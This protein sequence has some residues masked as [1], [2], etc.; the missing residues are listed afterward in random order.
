MDRLD[1]LGWAAGI[2]VMAHGV[3]LGVRVTDPAAMGSALS[4]LPPG[5]RLARGP[6]V[7]HLFSLVVG[8][9]VSPRGSVRRLNLLYRDALR[10]ARDREWEPVLE[11]LE[12]ELRRTVAEFAPRRVFVH[13]GVVRWRGRAILVPG[14]TF[15]GKTTLVSELVRAG[16]SYYSDEYAALDE[17]GRVH[18]FP[19][20]LSVRDGS[21]R[22]RDV[23][24][25]ELGGTSGRQPIPLGAVVM[26][27]YR[28]GATWRPRRR[29]E[30]EG[31]LALLGNAVSA[32]RRPD[33]AMAAVRSAMPGVLVLAGK[34]G[35]AD[36]A[37]RAI[38]RRADG[39]FD[40]EGPGPLQTAGSGVDA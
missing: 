28:S 25:E 36:G 34:R 10:V 39:W 12:T 11:A 23:A 21:H 2:S 7:D 6:K 38:L 26:T 16:A 17:H 35:E 37:A 19:K 33:R 29:S 8:G 18:P 5:W 27:E 32:R 9:S 30:G 31:A 15:T 24:P 3:R 20:P 14:R 22:G 40:Q 4:A 1:R 13:A